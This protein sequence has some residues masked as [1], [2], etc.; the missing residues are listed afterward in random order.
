ML[1]PVDIISVSTCVSIN[2][3]VDQMGS[4]GSG[5]SGYQKHAGL[6]LVVVFLRFV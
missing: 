5:G 1:W 4:G 3:V 6:N 2:V